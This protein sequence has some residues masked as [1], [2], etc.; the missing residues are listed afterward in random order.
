MGGSREKGLQVAC[1]QIFKGFDLAVVIA[2]AVGFGHEA[3]AAAVAGGDQIRN[4][5]ALKEGEIPHGRVDA[6]RQHPHLEQTL[7]HYGGLP[8][9]IPTLQ[10]Y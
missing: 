1:L 10:R 8:H 9:P 6:L 4:P 2:L 7:P 3:V 5:A